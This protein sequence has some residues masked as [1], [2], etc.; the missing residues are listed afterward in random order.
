MGENLKQSLS[1]QQ[2]AEWIGYINSFALENGEYRGGRHSKQHR[3]GMV[4]GALGVLGGR[5]RYPVQ[6]YED[7]NTEEKVGPWL[8]QIDW[9]RLW[10]SS[11]LFWGGMHCYS[12][13][14]S[15]TDAWR[16]VVFTWLDAN[17]NPETGWWR[18]GVPHIDTNQPLGGGA[19]IWP[20]YQHHDRPFP[21]P[22]QVIDGIL[23]LQKEDGSWLSFGSYLDLDA[24][25]GLAYMRSL[26][27]NH[28]PDEVRDAVHRYG[29]LA[30][31]KYPRYLA[32]KP[33]THHLLGTIGGLGLLNQLDSERFY[34]TV[35]WSDIFS[36][37][38]LYD[39][40]SVG[41]AA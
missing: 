23:A 24:L 20:I 38:R 40:A 15:C 12:M 28:R 8:E 1:D 26:A 36:D 35:K 18:K 6:F 22:K 32:G 27:P 33:D 14:R 37:V 21:Y 31:E 2:R 25:Y 10:E 4:T 11:H 16:Q 39:T 30:L 3:N 7:F 5:Q 41:C 13:S 34:D 17:L 29:T 9:S 19:H